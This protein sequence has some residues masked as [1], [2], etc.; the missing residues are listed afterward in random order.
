[1]A[2]SILLN[3]FIIGEVV[4]RYPRIYIFASDSLSVLERVVADVLNDHTGV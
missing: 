1:M 2:D 3:F 4:P